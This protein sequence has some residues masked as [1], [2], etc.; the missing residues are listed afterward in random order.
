MQKRYCS[1]GQIVWVDY[2]HACDDSAWKPVFRP[3]ALM[4]AAV[5]MHCP[6][7]EKRLDVNRLR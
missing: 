3:V 2:L 1:C 6:C 5:L 4:N 7:C